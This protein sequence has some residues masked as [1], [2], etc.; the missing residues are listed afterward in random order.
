M[1]KILYGILYAF[2]RLPWEIMYLFSTFIYF[3]LNYIIGYRRKV[4]YNNL[5]NSFPE[6]S[7]SEIKAIQRAFYRNFADYLVETLKS[8]SITQKDLDKRHTYSNLEVFQQCKAEGK[9]VILMAGHI[10]NWEWFIGLVKYL[11]TTHTF[12]LYHKVKNDFWNEQINAVRGK[13]GTKPLNM[14]TAAKYMLSTP[15]DGNHTYL[16]VADQS[17]KKVA[18]HHSI[19]FLNQD[20]PVFV[21]FDKI[22]IK[23]NMAVVFCKTTKT[24]QGFYHTHFERI[25]P[26][27]DSFRPFEVV[28]K[29]FQLLEKT[30]QE[31]PDNWLWSHKRW[32]YKKGIDY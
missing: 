16:F 2:S 25:L 22:A 24:K 15:N 26:E 14:K 6:K 5:R 21:G 32:K 4:I 18:I 11:P 10:F 1:N 19:P 27:G 30:L 12:A 13:F 3:I 20:T 17:P 31:N 7:E 8:F 28:D 9:E 23:R 29:F